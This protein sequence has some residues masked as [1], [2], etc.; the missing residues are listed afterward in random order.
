[1]TTPG[2]PHETVAGAGLELVTC[3]CWT[4][5]VTGRGDRK[6]KGKDTIVD[7]EPGRAA[8][9][10]A[11]GR[12]QGLGGAVGA[13]VGQLGDAGGVVCCGG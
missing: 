5:K 8:E 11:A 12:V 4:G 10:A 1:M 2:Q 3:K 6:G 9:G 13:R 7:A